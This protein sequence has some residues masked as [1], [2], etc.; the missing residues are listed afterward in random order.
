M[1]AAATSLDDAFRHHQAGR[2]DEAEALYR[3]LLRREPRNHEALHLLGMLSQ[4]AGRGEEA[5]VL[6]RRALAE[7]PD[8][9]LY[10]SNLAGVLGK[11][12]RPAEAIPH[13]H[14]AIRLSPGFA[15]AHNNLG[16]ALE[17]VGRLEEAEA[18][19]R[20]ALRLQEAY[21]E[22]HNNLGN[23]LQKRGP[24]A[25]A[26]AHHRRAL[27]LRAH[28]PE[29]VVNLAAALADAGQLDEAI[30]RYREAADLLP[31][32]PAAHSALL[33]SLHYKHGDDPELMAAEHARW[34]RR[35]AAALSPAAP[36]HANDRTPG[37]RLRVGYLSPDFRAHP[38]SR[39]LEPLLEHRDARDFEVVLYAD[40]AIS[41]NVT[42]RLRTQIDLWRHVA[43]LDDAALADLIRSDRVDVLV[44]LTGHMAANRLTVFARKPAPVQVSYIGYP[45]TT[46][47][48]AVDYRV[49]DSLHDP[50]GR[51]E[52]YHTECLVRLDP[53][54]W[55]IR[56]DDDA[57]DVN[58]LPALSSGRVAFG[59]LNKL[60]KAT[61]QTVHLWARV[62]EAVPGSTLTVLVGPRS[63]A[64]PHLAAMF[65]SHG[66]PPRRLRLV[67]R[68]PHDQY[69]RLYHA[70]DVALDTFPYNGHT[71]TL[72]ALWMG[73]P[74]VTLAGRTHVA[75][76]GLSVL[77]AAGLG[78]CVAFSP[79]AYVRAAA[80]LAADL[81]RL[82]SL[83]SALRQRVA[84]GPLCDGR[85]TARRREE[86]YRRMWAAWCASAGP[87]MSPHG[88]NSAPLLP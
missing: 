66:V 55:C 20:E 33:F 48:S 76:A 13:L 70:L 6:I 28:Y 47:L 7:V 38:V 46:G 4:Q 2:L 86:A 77:T 37:R 3:E 54:C 74:T 15:K 83:R 59:A 82:A 80:S 1:T 31:A 9:S 62:L 64:D 35:H 22:A 36:R 51:T 42:A 72:D 79:D 40:S 50:P 69:L 14:A 39:F 29:A 71:T 21:P 57:P 88:G 75:R 19:L 52:R 61:P 34:A 65:E 17:S 32:S 49:T 18:A 24:L 63:E 81:P 10:H 84:R 41:D 27:E 67:G 44:D 11:L 56:P 45:D 8:A 26:V 58:P 87:A 68:C 5:V 78:E 85:G 30:D 73:V 25:E 16:V 53:C 23:V 60:V 12:G 43:G